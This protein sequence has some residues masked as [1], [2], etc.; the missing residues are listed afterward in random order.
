MKNFRKVAGIF[1]AIDVVL[2]LCALYFF[3][4][5]KYKDQFL[6]NTYI[7]GIDVSDLS[8]DQA[9][10]KI[11]KTYEDYKLV[12]KFREDK[13]E[14]LTREAID[15]HYA[16]A[17]EIETLLEKQSPLALIIS[18]IHMSDYTADLDSS[19]DEELLNAVTSKWTELKK[20][21]MKKPVNAHLS[22]EDAEFK[23]AP[24]EAG[25]FLDKKKAMEKIREALDTDQIEL[26]FTKMEGIYEEPTVFSDDKNLAKE[27]EALNKV[28]KGVGTVTYE[29]PNGQT[30]VLDGVVM[31]DWLKKDKKGN[32]QKDQETWNQ[33]L[34][35]YVAK[36]CEDYDT[37][38]K[39]R[40]FMTHN[41]R[42]ITIPGRGYYGWKIDEEG[43]IAQLDEDIKA[44]K[45][46]THEPIYSQREA[47]S[48]DDNYGLG[49]MYVEVDILDQH[50]WLY[51]DG[52]VAVETDVVT[53]ENDGRHNTP[54][55]A[56]YVRAKVRNTVL[57]G[58][59]IGDGV[60]EWESPVSY[61]MPI[62]DTGVGM[63]DADWRGSFGGD[64][65]QWY[66]SHGCINLP[67]Y[68]TP[69]IFGTVE[70]GT[71]VMVYYD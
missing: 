47:S 33:K 31:K 50:L 34:Q 63:H 55:G 7:N 53:G 68:I 70:E 29:L 32:Y 23:V 5:I 30:Q 71:P 65:W 44:G 39:D 52:K 51:V 2:A 38:N 41:G 67:P 60:Y 36:L 62:T 13:T 48:M 12:V 25:T 42:K 14:E 26:D 64:I 35:E 54:S 43:E 10:E 8:I 66:G 11:A 1:L 6:P 56:F 15:Y 16:P 19:Y 58:P 37:V 59:P 46:V 28:L 40:E 18:D 22:Y 17:G 69:D 9:K 27:S 49:N 45:A 21:K 20:K 61:W 57:T 3:I 4:S 24:E